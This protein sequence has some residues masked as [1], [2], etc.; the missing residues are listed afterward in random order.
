MPKFKVVISLGVNSYVVEAKDEDEATEKAGDL[1]T[2]YLMNC[3]DVKDIVE[4]YPAT[5]EDEKEYLAEQAGLSQ[6]IEK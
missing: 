5:E 2:N 6:G 1:L 3:V 4:V